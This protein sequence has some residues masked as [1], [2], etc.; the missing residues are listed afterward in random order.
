M[1]LLALALLVCAPQA[2]AQKSNAP[3]AAQGAKNA[4]AARDKSTTARGRKATGGQ[5]E[6]KQE[7]KEKPADL[8]EK[9]RDELVKVTE[10]YKASL[11]NLISLRETSV[12]KSEEQLTKLKELYKDGIIARRAV[13][14][15]EAALAEA[16]H[17]VEEVRVQLA[18][19]DQ[20]LAETLAETEL[21]E[22]PAPLPQVATGKTTAPKPYLTRTAYMRYNGFANWTISDAWKVESFFNGRFGRH[23]PVS[24][25]GQT[26]LHNR[27]GFDHRN[28]MDVGLHPDSAEGRALISYLQSAGIPFLAFRQAIPGSATGPHIHVGRPS[29]RFR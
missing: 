29:H 18:A 11:R 13:E 2:S 25:F 8:R 10:E 20:M 4:K 23:L 12:K 15:S 22:L 9:T 1:A 16:R 27:L 6:S 19:A 28:S 17:K 7:T 14:E 21:P 3:L 24:A 26:D 5:D